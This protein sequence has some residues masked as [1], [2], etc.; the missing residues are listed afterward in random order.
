MGEKNES[1]SSFPIGKTAQERCFSYVPECYKVQP[2]YRADSD[3]KLADVPLINLDGMSDDPARR[4]IIIQ[5][6]ANACR[7]YGIFQVINHG[8]SQETLDGALSAAAGFFKLPNSAKA[9]FMSSDVHE[10]VRYGTSVRDGVDKVQFWRV[11]L[12][13]YAHPSRTGSDC[14]LITHMITVNSVNFD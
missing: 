10:P 11:F 6:I 4:S 5:E 14:G 3:S 12:K 9:K 1:S 8:I 13:H 7:C 2:S